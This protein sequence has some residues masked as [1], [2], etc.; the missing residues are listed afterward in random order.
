MPAG[1]L[2]RRPGDA[3]RF[4]EVESRER[5]LRWGSRCHRKARLRAK[6]G[7]HRRE[8]AAIGIR[9][10]LLRHRELPMIPG[11]EHQFRLFGRKWRAASH[12]PLEGCKARAGVPQLMLPP[13]L[14]AIRPQI[15]V[16]QRVIGVPDAATV[17]FMFDDNTGA[18]F[19]IAHLADIADHIV[20][21]G[22]VAH[23]LYELHGVAESGDLDKTPG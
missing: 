18:A 5:M 21:A 7:H 14:R 13:R 19:E 12:A 23:A 1:S 6:L 20:L 10:H 15:A 8:G 9:G 22:G 17:T 4:A 3:G 16:H 11:S 2:L